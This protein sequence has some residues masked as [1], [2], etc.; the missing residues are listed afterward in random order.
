ML[1]VY[2]VILCGSAALAA[3]AGL[4]LMRRF[5]P[6]VGL[7]PSSG[8]CMLLPSVGFL[9]VA[10]APAPVLSASLLVAVALAW[11]RPATRL[12]VQAVLM[13]AAILLGLTGLPAMQASYLQ[14][15]SALAALA[16][17]GVAWLVVAGAACAMSPHPRVFGYG[18]LLALLP[19]LAGPVLVTDTQGQALDAAILASAIGAVLLLRPGQLPVTLAARLPLGLLV[20]Y[21]QVAMVWHGAWQV[22]AASVAFWL[23]LCAWAW[24]EAD[25]WGQRYAR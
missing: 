13:I 18:S 15:I 4:R 1:V 21:V 9:A 23:A 12:L 11:W 14:S 17:A 2:M 3:G 24:V 5:A 25:P 19:L 6:M 7:P 16:V 8:W 20:G 10:G 22:A